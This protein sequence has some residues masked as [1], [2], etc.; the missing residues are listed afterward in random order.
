M[1]ACIAGLLII[2]LLFGMVRATPSLPPPL[3]APP[4][5]AL[6]RAPTCTRTRHLTDRLTACSV[7]P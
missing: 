7:R 3:L 6:L 2:V 4:L 1:P 5:L